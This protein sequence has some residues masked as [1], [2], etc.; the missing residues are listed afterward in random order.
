MFPTFLSYFTEILYLAP[1]GK[2][3]ENKEQKRNENDKKNSA[4]SSPGRGPG[5]GDFARIR[6]K[7]NSFLD[8]DGG[9]TQRR[10]HGAAA[11]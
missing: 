1:E 11:A 7:E 6:V 9:A 5:F 3:S 10:P 2:K 4:G 8:G